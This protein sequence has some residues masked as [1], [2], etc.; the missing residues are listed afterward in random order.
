MGKK[1]FRTREGELTI[2]FLVIVTAFLVILAG[3][4]NNNDK[5][6]A[7]GFDLIIAAALYSPIKMYIYRK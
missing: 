2:V 7:I 6:C 1:F 5:I 4:K 3:I